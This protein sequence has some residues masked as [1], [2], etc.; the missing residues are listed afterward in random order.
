[1]GK[2]MV[3]CFFSLNQSNHKNHH[4]F[5]HR[6]YL[7]GA[8]AQHRPWRAHATYPALACA[9]ATRYLSALRNTQRYNTSSSC[10]LGRVLTAWK[11]RGQVECWRWLFRKPEKKSRTIKHM[12]EGSWGNIP[13]W[14]YSARLNHTNASTVHRKWNVADFGIPRYG[15]KSWTLKLGHLEM[16]IPIWPFEHW[17][18]I[19]LAV[20]WFLW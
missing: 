8:V 16:T 9:G 3:S 15:S 17:N 13:W 18:P 4:V 7:Q 6:S 1:M 2:T 10:D 12:L 20:C 5:L 11:R 19:D 14:I